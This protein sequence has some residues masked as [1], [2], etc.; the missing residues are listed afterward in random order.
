MDLRILD[1]LELPTPINFLRLKGSNDETIA[2]SIGRL[3]DN[4]IRELY[5]RM[6]QKQ[7]DRLHRK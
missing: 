2:F 1:L 6:A 3:T 7:I 4:E 5:K